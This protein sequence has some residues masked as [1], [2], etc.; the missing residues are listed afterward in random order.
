MVRMASTDEDDYAVLA[1]PL[2]R[3]ALCA[4]AAGAANSA[5]SAYRALVETGAPHP[6][7]AGVAYHVRRLV[8]AGLLVEV[9]SI[10]R[11]GAAEHILEPTARGRSVVRAIEAFDRALT[12]RPDSGKRSGRGRR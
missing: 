2:R 6:S 1:H 5:V 7:L 12:E 11:R 10:Q 3:A 9:A 8:Q 4:I